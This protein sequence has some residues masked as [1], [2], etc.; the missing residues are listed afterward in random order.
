M[1]H[2]DD[3]KSVPIAVTPATTS[4]PHDDDQDTAVETAHQGPFAHLGS[5]R[6]SIL[7]AVFALA[8]AIDVLNISALLIMTPE[9][10]ADLDL[11]A[12]NVTW[13]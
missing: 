6:K 10:A 7:L 1:D 8:T 5:A 3:A 13:M 9:I 2:H 4:V 12:G 11:T